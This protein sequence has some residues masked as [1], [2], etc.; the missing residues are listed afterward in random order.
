MPKV[1]KKESHHLK[2]KRAISVERSNNVTY[3]TLET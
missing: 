3:I 2:K 1:F